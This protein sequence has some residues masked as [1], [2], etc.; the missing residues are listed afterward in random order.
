LPNFPLIYDFIDEAV[1]SGHGI[2]IHCQAGI[3][4][5]TTSLS[6]WLMKKKTMSFEDCLA[7]IRQK[8]SFVSP[9]FGFEKQLRAYEFVV[10]GREDA[11]DEF[12]KY[13][14]ITAP[15]CRVLAPDGAERE[16]PQHVGANDAADDD[17]IL[18]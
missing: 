11:K 7:L 8:R 2:L 4:R 18:F 6:S 3:S 16:L 12:D 17:D 9:N 13:M 1:E 5:S 14:N 15:K 10:L